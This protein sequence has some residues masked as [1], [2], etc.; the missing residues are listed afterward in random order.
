V[1][2]YIH[3]EGEHFALL[4]RR[5]AMSLLH[6]QHTAVGMITNAVGDIAQEAAP[7]GRV[8]AVAQHDEIV[9]FLQGEGDDGLCGVP[10][11]GYA[12][13][14]DLPLGGHRFDLLAP[15]LEVVLARLGLVLRWP[16]PKSEYQMKS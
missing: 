15:L 7:Q 9:P 14:G 6:D 4:S 8:I 1:H 2:V 3:H 11:P 12:G 5:R 10:P 16:F 13:D